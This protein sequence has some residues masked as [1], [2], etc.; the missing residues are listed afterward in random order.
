MKRIKRIILDKQW[1]DLRFDKNSAIIK[2]D[3]LENEIDDPPDPIDEKILDKIQGSLIGMAL[4]D[5]LGERVE[6]RPHE[7]LLSNPVTDLEGGGTWGL[8][9]GQ[10]Q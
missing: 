1:L 8:K 6:F 5:A 2:P 10:V 9:P 3:E 7:Y 4:G